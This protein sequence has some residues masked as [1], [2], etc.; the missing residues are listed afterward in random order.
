MAKQV[1]TIKFTGTIGGVTF[2]QMNGAY[3]ARAKSSLSAKKV[4][5]HPKF[6]QTR[7]YA[8]WLGEASKMASEVYRTLPLHKRK[9]ELYCELKKIA[10]A[11]VK[12]EINREQVMEELKRKVVGPR[13]K[14]IRIK[15][16]VRRNVALTLTQTGRTQSTARGC[17]EQISLRASPRLR[18]FVVPL[19]YDALLLYKNKGGLLHPHNQLPDAGEMTEHHQG[20]DKGGQ[21]YKR[22]VKNSNVGLIESKDLE[23]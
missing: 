13:V 19:F 7:M 16:D 4:N 20:Y 6:A 14:G 12:K 3:Y 2:Y 8:R 22:E 15:V 5:T 9:Y 11:L 21:P 18:A 17:K 10:Y 23:V 1:G